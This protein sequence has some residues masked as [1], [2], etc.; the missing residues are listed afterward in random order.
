MTK[1]V[2]I[3]IVNYNSGQFLNNCLES[4]YAHTKGVSFEII[5]VDN[6]SSDGSFV[7]I[8]ET[9]TSI[10]GLRNSSNLGFAAANNLGAKSAQGKYLLFLNPDTLLVDDAITAMHQFL[11]STGN[12]MAACG[13]R[14]Q[15]PDGSYSVS[16]GNFPTLFQQFSDIGFR[17]LYKRFY[18]RKLSISPPCSSTNPQ[19]VGYLSGA[20]VLIR[21]D[22]FQQIGGFDERYFMYYEDTDL[23]YRLHQ[24]GYQSW[25]LPQLSI[26][27]IGSSTSDSDG[28][29]NYSKYSMLEKS[30]Y[31]YFAKNHGAGS[32]FWAKIFQLIALLLHIGKF[33]YN[34]LKVVRITLKA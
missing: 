6:A 29:F 8:C 21:K 33:R 12:T 34:F 19:P 30:K 22:I 14:L 27:H 26:T 16:F 10:R 9:F 1:D 28:T 13:A 23:F 25:L 24:A 2:S 20:D 32:V 15:N 11:E 7:P 4:I 5:L 17:A 3:I 18:D 31:I